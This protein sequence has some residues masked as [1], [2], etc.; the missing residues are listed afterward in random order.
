ML[1]ASPSG[2][3]PFLSV[4]APVY[5]EEA[6]IERVVRYWQE[7]V[8]PLGLSWE[9]V[10]YNDGSADRT[11]EILRRLAQEIPQLRMVDGKVN[12]GYG[13]ALSTAIAHCKGRYIV[14]ID[15][16]GQFDLADI[17]HFLPKIREDGFDAVTG[18][19]VRKEDSFLRV[20]DRGLNLIVRCL[21]RTRLRDTNCA[22]KLVKREL[23][24]SLRLEATGYPLPTEICLKLVAMGAR[25]TECPVRHLERQ[26]G[27]SSLKIWRTGWR[28][29]R[30][31]WYLRK[32]L[33]LHRSGILRAL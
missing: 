14:T 33:A 21:F 26:G 12:R 1:G 6:N 5:N 2:A 24:Q 10:L 20:A 8:A 31:L 19:R 27:A 32:Q 30:F 22:L 16:D 15:S 9:F 17:Q 7:C 23:L 25:L 13:H 18:Y 29:W 11:G 4:A 28:M 3:V